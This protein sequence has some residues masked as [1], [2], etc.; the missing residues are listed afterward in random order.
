VPSTLLAV[1][2]S[3][4]MRKVLEIT[5]TGPDFHVT[6]V[7]SEAAA[8]EK[9]KSLSPDLVVCD[10]SLDPKSGYDVCK[11]I[12]AASPSTPVLLLSSKQNPYD[13]AKGQA[14]GADDHMDK[15]FD[16]Q[17]MLD[18]AKKLVAGGGAKPAAA[19]AP[20]A[21]S[22][23]RTLDL[24]AT[25]PLATSPLAAKPAAQ[26]PA[27][28]PAPAAAEPA[29]R[30]KTL[31]YSPGQVPVGQHNA[32]TPAA[33]QKPAAA[34]APAAPAV[35]A[36]KPAAAA[37]APAVGGAEARRGRPGLCRGAAQRAQVEAR[38]AGAHARAGRRRARA[39][40]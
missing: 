32:P 31:L 20:A 26:K 2:D 21:A 22:P 15:P 19:A 3:A 4:T 39:L 1:D 38:R 37:P 9:L 14:A 10:V 17:Q 18:R 24:G 6:A 28:A 33:A 11:A 35:A 7:A 29:G 36:Q 23:A 40:A 5:F 13:A 25:M 12:K 16:T 27:A 30:A 8:L 34:P